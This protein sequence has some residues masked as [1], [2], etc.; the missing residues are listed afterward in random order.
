MNQY[1]CLVIILY[2]ISVFGTRTNSQANVFNTAHHMHRKNIKLEVKGGREVFPA[3]KNTTTELELYFGVL[4]PEHPQEKE[5]SF[6]EAL[7]AMELAIRRLQQPGG[8]FEEYSIF[9]E[10]RDT[11][12]SSTYCSLGAFDLYSKQPQ[13]GVIIPFKGIQHFEL[14]F[15]D[16]FELKMLQIL[17]SGQSKII[18]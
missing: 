13:G 6:M 14:D 16:C 4:L 5:C 9:V 2:V 1:K 18:R 10:Y 11:K 3:K 17:Y 8:L 7:S 15:F 12:S